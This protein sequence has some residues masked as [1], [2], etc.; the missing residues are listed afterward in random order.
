MK[1]LR[2]LFLLVPL[3]LAGC[4]PSAQ[5][6]ADYSAVQ[7]SGVTPAIYDKMVHGDDLS[8]HDIEDLARA[9]VNSGIVLRYIRDHGTVYYLSSGDIKAMQGAGVDPSV[10]DYM[11]QTAR[12]GWWG[13]GAY[14]YPYAGWGYGP[15]WYGP[16]PYGPGFGG[17]IFIG[18]GRGGYH[19]HH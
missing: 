7:Q 3:F 1:A 14:P 13:P 5:Q 19:H 12:G 8:I 16:Y 18:G 17:A 11:L 4:A 6:M 2:Y 10:V 9:H 15:W